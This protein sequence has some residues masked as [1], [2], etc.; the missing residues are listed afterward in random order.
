MFREMRCSRVENHFALPLL[1]KGQSLIITIPRK[2][3]SERQRRK[4]AQ[5]KI[6][7]SVLGQLLRAFWFYPSPLAG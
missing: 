1:E 3:C 2:A 5:S 7:V 6:T 4:V